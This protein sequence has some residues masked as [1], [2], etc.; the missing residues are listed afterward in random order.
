MPK[1]FEWN[2][3]KFFFFS[4]EGIPLEKCL[5]HV[6]KGEKTA[7]YWVIPNVSMESSWGM[8]PKELNEL[9]KIV[10][11]KRDLILERWNEYFS[12]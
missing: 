9:E 2:G 11:E 10:E 12:D 4:N 8:S 5:I 1:I 3:F 6:R 7:K